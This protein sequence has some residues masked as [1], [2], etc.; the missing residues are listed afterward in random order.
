MATVKFY[1]DKEKTNQVYPDI[2][3][4]GNYPGVTVGLANNL[5]STDGVTDVDTWRYRSTAGKE[6]VSDGY[7]TIQK[8]IGSTTSST[9]EESLTYNLL[10]TGVTAITVNSSTFKTKI[11]TSGTYN[12]IY[13]PIIS[14][15]SALVYSL[16]KSTFANY[17]NMATGTYT[18]TYTAVVSPVDTSSV[19]S[20]FTQSTFVSKVSETPGTYTF[21]Y[22]GSNWQLDGSNVTMSQYGITTKGTETSGTTITIYYTSNSWYVGSASVS[23]S[24]Y[25]IATTGSEAVGDTITISY[26]ANNWQLNGSNVTLSQYGITISSGTAAIDDNIQ[27]VFVAEQ[28]GAIVTTN[29]TALYSVGMNQFNKNGSQIFTGYTIGSNGAITTASGT[30]VIYFKCLGGEVYTIYDSNANATGRVG[31]ISTVPT[32]SS[33]VTVLSTVSSSEWAD[34]LVNNTYMKHYQPSGDGY[35]VVT[36]SDLDDLC[37]H[38]TWEA[39]RDEEYESY[40]AYTYEIPYTDSNGTVITTYGLVNLDNTT[41]YYDEINFE[42]GK[43]YKRTARIEYSAEN[44][45]TVQGYGV[46]YLY[47]DNWIY[48]GVDT[49][50]YTLEDESSSYRISDYGTEEFIGT[51]LPLTAQ[52]FYQDNLKNKIRFSMEVIDNKV[53]EVNSS[54]N[55]TEYASARAVYNLDNALRHILGL[56]VET[57]STTKTYNVGDY[58]VHDGKLWKCTTAV[59]KA[60]AWTGNGLLLNTGSSTTEG[61]VLDYDSAKWLAYL[62]ADRPGQPCS[63]PS[64]YSRDNGTYEVH[65][66]YATYSNDY[67]YNSIEELAEATG[68]VVSSKIGATALFNYNSAN[69]HWT[70]SYLFKAN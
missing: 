33:T 58:V 68:I 17:V 4:D 44:L 49:V 43:F 59:T 52:I 13:T 20:T 39:V 19:I 30:N 65:L 5:T 16:N 9:I 31:F 24:S 69:N 3:P 60:G 56:D 12:F 53:E 2:N 67:T 8:L 61:F 63:L 70:E 62:D 50:E 35:L 15:S 23:M 14:Y 7:A 6:G 10:T 11:S 37:C 54:S 64:I 45:A 41:S 51:T 36:T 34:Y 29:P 57:F 48:Y 25:G 32:T 18:F 1:D 22:N 42:E 47:D 46:P 55:Y 27:I 26:T 66:M 38:L 40:F 21:T 28:I